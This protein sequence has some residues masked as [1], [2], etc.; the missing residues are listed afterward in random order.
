RVYAAEDLR[1]LVR[2]AGEMDQAVD[3]CGD[4]GFRFGGGGAGG[5]R[6]FIDEFDGA[7]K[8]L[9]AIVGA[10]F[11]P[12]VHGGPRRADGVAQILAGGMG[13]VIQMLATRGIGGQTAT[14]FA[15]GEFPPDVE[16]VG[17]ANV[18]PGH[19]ASF[20]FCGSAAL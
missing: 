17:F 7:I 5:T 16:L 13:E 19:G 15:A 18:Q 3:G 10:G 4:F 8:D 6:D 20:E 9:A 2:P 1:E 12:A 11:A 14:A